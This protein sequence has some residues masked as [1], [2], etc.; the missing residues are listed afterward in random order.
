MLHAPRDCRQLGWRIRAN[1][2]PPV[3][4]SPKPRARSRR[5]GQPLGTERPR[6][7]RPFRRRRCR[8][9]RCRHVPGRDLV[10]ARRPCGLAAALGPGVP[11]R[12]GRAGHQRR[13]HRSARPCCADA[14]RPADQV[15]GADRR[16]RQRRPGRAG[17]VARVR[18]TLRRSDPLRAADAARRGRAA[19]ERQ[20]RLG[21][22]ARPAE[23]W[24]CRCFTRMA[25]GARVD[26]HRRAVSP[27]RRRPRAPGRS[28][29]AER[30]TRLR[31]EPRP[32]RRRDQRAQP[33]RSARPG[34]ST[35]RWRRVERPSGPCD[36][37][38]AVVVVSTPPRRLDRGDVDL[39]HLH[40]RLEHALVHR[41]DRGRPSR[42]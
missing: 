4:A 39:P 21:L 5:R 25:G 22:A 24:P 9:P 11:R 18:A 32:R 29:A 15:G 13:P 3:D 37:G 35:R 41:R 38:D 17:R 2:W 7:R 12:P 26:D 8:D 36:T 19:V 42:R 31:P 23:P 27:V 34:P 14:G 16:S 6:R 33:G 40:H 28:L 10:G 30:F 20:R 1:A